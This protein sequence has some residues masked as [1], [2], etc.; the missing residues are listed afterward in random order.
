VIWYGGPIAADRVIGRL[1][2]GLLE[3]SD[4]WLVDL[5]EKSTGRRIEAGTLAQAWL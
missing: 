5:P 4:D 1:G 2:T 3:P